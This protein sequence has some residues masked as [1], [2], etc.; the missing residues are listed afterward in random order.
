MSQRCSRGVDR[1]FRVAGVAVLL[2][3]AGCGQPS[4][5]AE[6]RYLVTSTPLLLGLGNTGLCIAVD[7]RDP[8]GVWWWEPGGSGCA[9]RSTGPEIFHADQATVA[10]STESGAFTAAFRLQLHSATPPSFLDVRLVGKDGRMRTLD[11]RS[12]VAV[13]H[14]QDLIVPEQPPRPR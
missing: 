8:H 9:T 1:A 11:Y 12:A 4:A 14:R 10:R 13:H 3:L 6:G 5:Q 7:P 2:V